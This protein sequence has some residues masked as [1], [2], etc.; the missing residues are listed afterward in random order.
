FFMVVV[1]MTQKDLADLTLPIAITAE[2]DK[3][4][5]N[6]TRYIVNVDRQGVIQYKG[7]S[8]TLGELKQLLNRLK[9]RYGRYKD[10]G[11]P[12]PQ[13]VEKHGSDPGG[14]YGSELFVLVRAD[15]DTPWQ[16]VQWIMTIMAEEKLYKL[17]FGAKQYA[18]GDYLKPDKAAG[19]E[20]VKSL[21]GQW[22][23]N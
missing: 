3:S 13:R 17:Q 8:Y 19:L 4:N 2:P 18:D 21:G 1:D 20:E 11:K 15:K 7:K 12:K 23:E 16:H 5:D 9:R 6:D 10:F 14:Q 22:K